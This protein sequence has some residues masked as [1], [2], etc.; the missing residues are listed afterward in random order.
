MRKFLLLFLCSFSLYAQSFADRNKKTLITA[1]PKT[2]GRFTYE[3]TGTS[4]N[5]LFKVS[6]DYWD[7]NYHLESDNAGVAANKADQSLWTAQDKSFFFVSVGVKDIN[8]SYNDFFSELN[9][10]TVELGLS[11]A[12]NSVYWVNWAKLDQYYSPIKQ[13][14]FY[15]KL[16]VNNTFSKYYDTVNEIETKQSEWPLFNYGAQLD[17]IAYRKRIWFPLTFTL[18][19][20]MPVD[21]TKPYSAIPSSIDAESTKYDIGKPIGKY[22]NVLDKG[23]WNSRFSLSTLYLLGDFS[24]SNWIDQKLSR[25]CLLPNYSTYGTIDGQWTNLAGASIGLLKDKYDSTNKASLDIKPLLQFG[26]DWQ[27]DPVSHVWSKPY[28]IFSFKGTIK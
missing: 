19:R 28:W 27:S 5:V 4:A 13:W 1:L 2:D 12:F 21:N 18:S 3:I 8:K 22:G 16:F 23:Q 7:R 10:P 17:Y 9:Q 15:A 26:V 14:D 24:G 20:G 6:P 11:F 25:L